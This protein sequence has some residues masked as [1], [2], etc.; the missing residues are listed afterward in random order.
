MRVLRF[1][2]HGLKL[3]ES[4]T[5][6]MDLYASDN[7]RS[8]SFTYEALGNGSPVRIL[9][10][11]GIAGINASG[12][13]TALRALDLVLCIA[14]GKQIGSIANDLMPLIGMVKD[15]LNTD[16]IFEHEHHIYRLTSELKH[17][18]H[19]TG[20]FSFVRETLAIF[21]RRMSKAMLS[22]AFTDLKW[23]TLTTRGIGVPG[24]NGEL[25]REVLDYLPNDRSISGALV[26]GS[27]SN[28]MAN[29]TPLLPSF[30][31]NPVPQVFSLFDPSI[32]SIFA[33]GERL[34]L[35]FK[36]EDSDYEMNPMSLINTVSAGTL[37][38][39]FILSQALTVLS[40]GGYLL[41]DEIENSI[42]KQ[43]VFT[44]M[45]LF[46]S[47]A[48]NPRG[49]VLVFTTHYPELLDHFTR[50]D[51]IW[52]AVRRS[53]GFSLVHLADNLS[54]ADVKKSVAF[55]ANEIQGTAPSA[56]MVRQLRDFTKEIVNAR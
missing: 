54:R 2:M 48:T 46:A 37:R 26:K 47:S 11:I 34:H 15:S 49:A 5:L 44:I 30:V 35:K 51:N 45:D 38:G 55:F 12:K 8:T 10:T 14:N 41:V 18:P 17:D 29:L 52:F 19:S 1:Q 43:L 56:K 3:H 22:K 53:S 9:T 6:S 16:I 13:T 25:T 39:S 28:V 27:A 23:K 4:E 24:Q 40:T 20:G 32:E 7:V 33:E 21:P 42:N 31:L 50:K 36:G